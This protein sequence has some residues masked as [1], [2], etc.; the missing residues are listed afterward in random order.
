MPK[1]ILNKP[2]T[3][4]ESTD[5]RET[6]ELERRRLAALKAEQ[7]SRAFGERLGLAL[8]SVVRQVSSQRMH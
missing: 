2:Y 1:P 8:L 3:R 4:A 7:L 6:F 5:I